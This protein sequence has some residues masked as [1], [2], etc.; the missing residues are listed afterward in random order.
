MPCI[1]SSD[2]PF[3]TVKM[4]MTFIHILDLHKRFNA[5]NDVLAPP[6]ASQQ[7]FYLDFFAN[8]VE[9]GGGA[10]NFYVKHLLKSWLK[11]VFSWSWK[12]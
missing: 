7:F 3:N 5:G 2:L 6:L 1:S 10:S 8:W 4:V 11:E 12:F 9:E